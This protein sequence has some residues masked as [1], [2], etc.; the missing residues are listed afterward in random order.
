MRNVLDTMRD[1]G[2]SAKNFDRSC[3]MLLGS[4]KRAITVA[5]E[6]SATNMSP[7]TNLALSATPAVLASRSDSATMSGLNS[8]P[9][10]LA[11][12]LAAAMTLRPSPDPRSI[13]KS[14]GPTPGHVHHLLDERR[15]RGDPDDVLAGLADFGLEGFF[16]LLGG[17][18]SRGDQQEDE[19]NGPCDG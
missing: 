16:G 2:A 1:P 4:R 9:S 6:M 14:L 18:G 3:S 5:F 8:T 13:T 17:R 12:R 10:A 11:P 7:W 19:G 15:R